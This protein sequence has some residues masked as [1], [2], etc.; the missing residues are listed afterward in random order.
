MTLSSSLHAVRY[1]EED[2]DDS[3][4]TALFTK[5]LADICH[6]GDPMWQASRVARLR[7]LIAVEAWSDS[8]LA[9]IALRLPEWKLRRLVY[10]GG[11]WYCALSRHREMPDWLDQAVEAH[12]P[13]MP[14]AIVRALHEAIHA[15]H[16]VQVRADS[17]V[18]PDRGFEPFQCDNFS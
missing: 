2:G 4:R 7:R 13:I 1:V 16:S 9:L 14:M 3:P 10:D 11:E 8:A 6:G 5:L 15:P 17:K 12:H 18:D